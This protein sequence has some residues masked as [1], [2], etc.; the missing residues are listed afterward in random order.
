MHNQIRS[1]TAVFGLLAVGVVVTVSVYFFFKSRIVRAYPPAPAA[2]IV[3]FLTKPTRT[4]FGV[5]P[6]LGTLYT[7]PWTDGSL[8]GGAF[9]DDLGRA[10]GEIPVPANTIL[11][12]SVDSTIRDLSALSKLDPYDLQILSIPGQNQITDAAM[13]AI[14]HLVGLRSLQLAGVRLTDESLRHLSGLIFLE[15]LDL[16]KCPIYDEAVPYLSRLTSLRSLLLF[17]SR[18]TTESVARLRELLPDCAISF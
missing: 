4:R 17:R 18:M 3:S 11:M 6:G 1:V 14:G 12:L 2:R 8:P 16:Q 15:H 10:A 5:A 7:R 13:P 9:W